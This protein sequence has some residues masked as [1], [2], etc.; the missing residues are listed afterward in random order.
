MIAKFALNQ[1]M[2]HYVLVVY[3]MAIASAIITP[4]AILLDRESRPKLTFSILAKT[5]VLSLFD[6]VLDQ[7]LF[8]IGM[9]YTTVSFSSAMCNMLPAFAFLM[10]W[11]F[12][13]EE[14]NI[15]RLHGQAKVLGTIVTVGGAMI[16]TL[17]KG[18]AYMLKSF[19]AELS[20]TALIC[21]FGLVE[22]VV[23]ALVVESRS[24]TVW[25]I[26]LDTNFLAVIYGGI[27]SGVGYYIV[28]VVIKERGPVFFTAFNPLS[29]IIVAILASIITAEEM[30]VGRVI[31]AIIIIGGLYLVLWGKSKDK[32]SSPAQSEMEVKTDQDIE[33]NQ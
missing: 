21:V 6:P 20:L 1:G 33:I 3:R 25:S 4:F 16:L 18:P 17:V 11:I 19:P 12:G 9:K 2:S 27:L 22:A 32:S 29:T 13:L 10:A 24:N 14:V 5:M 15:R 26:N 28:G 23:L 7:N 31:G 30:Y 8:Y